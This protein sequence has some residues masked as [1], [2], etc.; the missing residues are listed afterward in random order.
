MPGVNALL[1]KRRRP[2]LFG[3]T[4]PNLVWI[5]VVWLVA[6]LT[7]YIFAIFKPLYEGLTSG[8]ESAGSYLNSSGIL[9][10][11]I[12][13]GIGLVLF[14]V[15][16]VWNRSRGVERSQVFATIPPD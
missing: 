3:D 1:A 2:D 14:F 16:L 13:I 5:A 7:I 4:S 12:V 9:A 6:I 11:L 8:D 10:A 15:N